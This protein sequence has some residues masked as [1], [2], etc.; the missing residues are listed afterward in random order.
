MVECNLAISDFLDVTFDLKSG[1]YYHYTKQNNK[2]LHKQSNHPPS[3]IKQ[4]PSMISKQV[5]G[6]S[7]DSD[8]F[9]KAAPNYNTA[10]KKSGFNE[11]IKYSL[12]QPKQRNRTRQIIL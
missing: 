2:I 5:S 3:I 12:S 4:I 11:N 1:T 6:I 9:N 8:H 10:L 7:C